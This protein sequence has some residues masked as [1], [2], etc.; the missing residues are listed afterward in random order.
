[1]GGIQKMKRILAW[2]IPFL[3]IIAFAAAIIVNKFEKK[4]KWI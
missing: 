2:V 4:M 3:L 1:M